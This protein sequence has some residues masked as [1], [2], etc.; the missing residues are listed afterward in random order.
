MSGFMAHTSM[1]FLYLNWEGVGIPLLI[2]ILIS[3]C[4]GYVKF[5]YRTSHKMSTRNYVINWCKTWTQKTKNDVAQNDHGKKRFRWLEFVNFNFSIFDVSTYVS[6][7][8]C[9]FVSC[10]CVGKPKTVQSVSI[11]G[12]FENTIWKL[13]KP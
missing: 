8:V 11:V 4:F 13:G 6:T 9:D 12:K 7:N 10:A 5:T 2:S 3:E 1:V